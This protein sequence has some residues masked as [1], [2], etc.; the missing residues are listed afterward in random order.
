MI[1]YP[2]GIRKNNTK[3]LKQSV[4]NRGMTLEKELNLSNEYYLQANICN[5]HKKPTPVQIVSV[6]YPERSKARI[7]EAYFKTPSTTDYNG[8]YRGFAIDFE[9][10]E[11]NCKTS[12]P[13]ALIHPHQIKHLESVIFHGAIAFLIIRFTQYDETYLI[14][15]TK[16]C[17][18]YHQ[19]RRS[20]PYS[21]CQKNGYLIR[22]TFSPPLDYIKT[23][24]QLLK[25]KENE[26]I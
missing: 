23:V 25:E 14:D 1:K 6:D 4:A 26:K 11:C 13:F 21:W 19:K 24:D 12:F 8:V 5:I 3:C 9:A 10:K 7:C 2:N 17:Y 20:L 22:R 15:A 18:K 16:V